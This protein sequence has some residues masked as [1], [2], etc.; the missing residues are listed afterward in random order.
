M[1]PL[2][3]LAEAAGIEPGYHDIW[4]NHI[5]ATPDQKRRMLAAMGIAAAD[6]R[7]QQ[8]SL[9]AI[10][11]RRWGR[12]VEPVSVIAAEAQPGHAIL[13]VCTGTGDL[14]FAFLKKTKGQARIVATDFCPDPDAE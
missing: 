6:E 8:A 11:E 2:D 1:D 10:A 9:R 3:A 5:V 4:H 14:A 13:D 12:L 7:Q